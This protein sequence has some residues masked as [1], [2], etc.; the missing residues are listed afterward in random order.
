VKAVQAYTVAGES[1]F[2]PLPMTHIPGT[3]RDGDPRDFRTPLIGEH[4]REILGEL[5]FD[6]HWIDDRIASGT[7][8]ETTRP[9]AG[10]VQ[11][12]TRSTSGTVPET[13]RPT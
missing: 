12:T 7:V 13:T 1:A 11:E 10:T 3:P 2:G 8:L 5:G 4:S 6:A 9:T